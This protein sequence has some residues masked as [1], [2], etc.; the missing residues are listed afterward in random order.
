MKERMSVT[1]KAMTR[2]QE[3]QR[4]IRLY[5]EQTGETEVDM[6]KVAEFATN[7]GWP[8]PK[9]IDP[10]MLLAKQFRAAAREEMRYDK[11]TRKPYRAYHAIPV[12]QGAV[13]LHLWIDIDE[14]PRAP[15]LKSLVKRREQMVDD[16]LQATLDAEHWNRILPDEEPIIL[17]MDL[18]LDIEWRKNIP[19]DDE[20]ED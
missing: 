2:Q 1:R 4:L 9:P 10:L 12:M 8:L 20:E 11:V 15:M 16:G 19:E 18:T 17:E 7:M 13:Q 3:M 14:A 6:R 5:K